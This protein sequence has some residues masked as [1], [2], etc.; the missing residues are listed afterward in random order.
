MRGVGAT[1]CN[2]L[3]GGASQL[4]HPW[5]CKLRHAYCRPFSQFMYARLKQ[6]TKQSQKEVQL[7]AASEEGEKS[8]GDDD[9]FDDV[10]DE[11][12]EEADGTQEVAALRRRGPGRGGSGGKQCKQAAAPAPAAPQGEE[13]VSV[14]PWMWLMPHLV[15]MGYQVGLPGR[16]ARWDIRQ[17]WGAAADTSLQKACQC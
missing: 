3:E 1:W 16:H 17:G 12:A 9:F 13:R 6:S 5:L 10:A 7:G 14:R 4:Q 15:Q 8:D 11:K 2:T